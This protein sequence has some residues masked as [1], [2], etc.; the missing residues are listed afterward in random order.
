MKQSQ[1]LELLKE[2]SQRLELLMSVSDEIRGFSPSFVKALADKLAE[3]KESGRLVKKDECNN[4]FHT[5]IVQAVTHHLSM[6]LWG[7]DD[8]LAWS[9]YGDYEEK[10]S[11]MIETAR[12]FLDAIRKDK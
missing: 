3:L 11:Q 9:A 10:C 7:L 6:Q 8:S 12:E 2:Q 5:G 4:L 1:R